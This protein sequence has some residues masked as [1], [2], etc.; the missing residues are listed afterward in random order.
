ME[1]ILVG[2]TQAVAGI[3]LKVAEVFNFWQFPWGRGGA[4]ATSP[5]LS[6]FYGFLLGL[7][8]LP[9]CHKPGTIISWLSLLLEK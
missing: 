7:L 3:V 4:P 9:G 1:T 6:L 8:Q 2:F 5:S